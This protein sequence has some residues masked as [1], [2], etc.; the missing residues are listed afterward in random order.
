M[1]TAV[2]IVGAR[3]QF[4]K[5]APV[6]RAFDAR[7]DS[8]GHRIVHTGQH[9]DEA[10]SAVFFDE[11]EIPKPDI[12]LD[13]GSGPHGRQT[14]AMLA[15]LESEFEASSPDVV[16]VYGDTNSTLAGALAAVKMQIPVCHIEAGLR[17]FN[18]SMPE[19]INRLVTDHC[20]DRLYAPTPV[21]MA[22]LAR[23]GLGD[24]AVRSGDVMLD[25]FRFNLRLAEEK[26]AVMDRH[27]LREGEYGIV[28]IHRPANTTKAALE[29]ILGALEKIADTDIPLLFP[30]HPRTRAM[31]DLSS[32]AEDSAL[33]IVEPLSYLDMLRA[34]KSARIVLTDSGGLQKEAAIAGTPCITLRDETEWTETVDMGANA[35]VGQSAEHLERAVRKVLRGGPAHWEDAI[36]EH[37][38][39]GAAARII[40][41][42]V[43]SWSGA[44]PEEDT[45]RRSNGR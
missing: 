30:M 32:R 28:T 40:V 41:D 42:D 37:Y 14:A 35:L 3:P 2:S 13:V 15:A 38:G 20:A 8:I 21:A 27:G 12:D 39:D 29:R 4:I 22:H 43:V 24:R 31:L 7:A 23:E 33:Q 36:R 9:Y 26:S 16:I 25:A 17:S 10:M 11:L 45:R 1:K 44:A 5:L 18:R 19:E 6:S 34:L